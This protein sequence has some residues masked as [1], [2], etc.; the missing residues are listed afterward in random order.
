[1]FFVSRLRAPKITSGHGDIEK[2]VRKWCS[3]NQTVSKP[4]LSARMHCSSVSSITGGSEMTGRC[5][6]YARLNLM[7]PP[8]PREKNMRTTIQARR[9][10]AKLQLE[11]NVYLDS[12]GLCHKFCSGGHEGTSCPCLGRV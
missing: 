10:V 11:R 5:I 6:S 9:I 7:L 3:T 1:M 8:T 2:P 4:I 12:L